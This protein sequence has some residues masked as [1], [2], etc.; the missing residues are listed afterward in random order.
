VDL[1]Q[2]ERVIIHQALN[3]WKG[4]TVDGIRGP[5][6]YLAASNRTESLATLI[7]GL[8]GWGLT[9]HDIGYIRMC[10]AEYA[11]HNERILAKKGAHL[12]PPFQSSVQKLFAKLEAAID[13]RAERAWSLSQRS[14]AGQFVPGNSA[15]SKDETAKP[16]QFR[17]YR[18]DEENIETLLAAGYATNQTG[19]V[20]RALLEALERSIASS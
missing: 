5:D 1:S 13:P 4:R 7:D 14:D 11:P 18:A 20:R 2:D 9:A 10:L 8:M 12:V 17:L 19:V 6:V 3:W 16:K 15:A